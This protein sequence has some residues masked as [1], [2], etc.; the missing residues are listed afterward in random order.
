MKLLSELASDL[1]YGITAFKLRAEQKRTDDALRDSEEKLRHAN[2]LLDTVTE[3]TRV[4]I[5]TM[6]MDFRYTY[7][8]QS[9]QEEIA[10]LS[11][12]EIQIGTS[13]IDTFADSPEQLEVAVKEWDRTLKGIS[14]NNIVE[15][16]DP[17]RYRRVYSV[18]RTPIRNSQGKVIGAGEVA[19]DITEQE[20]AKKAL[21]ETETRYQKSVQPDDRGFRSS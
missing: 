20:L 2:E 21:A 1:A 5:S 18:R 6:D 9:Y 12:K 15:F 10:R 3:G 17:G 16:G 8:T 19:S 4:I 13:M 11:G 7:F 14:S